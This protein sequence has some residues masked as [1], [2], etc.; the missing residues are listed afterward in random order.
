MIEARPRSSLGAT[1]LD[2]VES[3]H[4]FCFAGYHA[5]GREGWGALSVLNYV[6]LAP[7]AALRPQPIDGV[8]L[9]TVVRKGVIAHAGSLGGNCRTVAGEVQLISPGPGMT[10]ADI[11]P[12]A[13]PAEYVEIRIRSQSPGDRAQRRSVAFPARSHSGHLLTLASGFAEDRPAPS[14]TAPARVLGG[15][16]SP[17]DR[18][19]YVLE[20]DR[21]V[22]LV[23]L[24]GCVEVNGVPIDTH[25]G[26][27]VADETLLRIEAGRAAEI[28]FIETR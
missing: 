15:R 14:L 3:A 17:G 13:R 6:T 1:S 22:Y 25:A 24:S 10:H 11:N 23:A 18:L 12:S 9:I 21:L 2:G 5:V 7:R 19:D 4:H 20:S 16:I 28:L 8:E 27:A 26:A